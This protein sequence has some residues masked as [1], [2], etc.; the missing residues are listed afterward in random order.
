VTWALVAIDATSLVQDLSGWADAAWI[1]A[2]GGWAGDVHVGAGSLALSAF[3]PHFAIGA[4]L[5]HSLS[6]S[7]KYSHLLYFRFV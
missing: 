1:L 4:G 7:W 5:L 2:A 6:S 3:G